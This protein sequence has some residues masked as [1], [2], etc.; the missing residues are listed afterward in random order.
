MS[1]DAYLAAHH[2]VIDLAALVGLG[3]SVEYAYAQV[4][5]RRW[6]RVHPA[7]FVATPAR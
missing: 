1:I 2:Q 3:R 6:Q 5:A 7:V 4:A